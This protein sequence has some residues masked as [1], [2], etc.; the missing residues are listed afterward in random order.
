MPLKDIHP[1]EAILFGLLY[2]KLWALSR[3]PFHA[4][5][6][7]GRMLVKVLGPIL[8]SRS[9]VCL[10]AL[11]RAFGSEMGP[12]EI[13]KLHKA[14]LSHFS[15]M[16]MEIPHIL[17]ISNANLERY[18][19][20]ENPHVLEQALERGRGALMLTAHFGNWEL[21]SV[22]LSLRFG[23]RG[24][25]IV[26]P[27]DFAPADRLFRLLRS[28]FGTE[29]IPKQRSMRRVL[30]A[31]KENQPVG[32]L[33]DQNVDWYEGVF[34]PF[35][36]QWACTNKGLALVALR[37]QAPVIP[38]FSVKQPDGR[39]RVR[40]EGPLALIQTGDRTSDVEENTARF[41]RVIER[42]VRSHPEQWFWFHRRWKTR[43]Y[44]PWPRDLR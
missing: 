43:P 35:L 21:M 3:I 2:A 19:T 37:T 32:V 9:R 20:F 8:G 10:E 16:V 25:V 11:E 17:R 38:V 24:A 18:V 6:G 28:R 7:M 15:E 12:E 23:I 13:R 14:V 41:T 44:H 4:A 39:Y 27:M 31:L 30:S 34:V 33:L 26:R 36:G 40:M 22:A 5:Q 1:G 42:Y 29:I